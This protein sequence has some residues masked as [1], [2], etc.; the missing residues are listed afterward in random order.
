VAGND[1]DHNIILNSTGLPNAGLPQGVGIS[2]CCGVGP[3]NTFTNNVVY[4][5]PGGI[6]DAPGITLN[7]NTTASP[8]LADPANHDYRTTPSSPTLLSTWTLWDGNLGT[9]PATDPQT[10]P[11][12]P[13]AARGTTARRVRYPA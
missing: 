1:I 5:N 2:T 6:A 10:P 3:G 8:N 7:N 9:T 12:S 11:G 4:N 13:A